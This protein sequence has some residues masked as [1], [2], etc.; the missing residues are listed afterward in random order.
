MSGDSGERWWE[1]PPSKGS[2]PPPI[3][4]PMQ[5]P[6]QEGQP[7]A[8]GYPAPPSYPPSY[9]QPQ[10]YPPPPYPQTNQGGY[11]PHYQPGYPS[12]PRSHT[13]GMAIGSLVASGLA[14]PLGFLRVGPLAAIVGVV[15]GI[16]ALNQIKQSGENGRGLA[17]AG[18]IVGGLILA[19]TVILF[20]VG[21]AWFAMNPYR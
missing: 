15:L 7:P 16:I 8:P 13:N 5:P 18:I 11:P 12:P 9:Q 4:P 1:Q 19:L 6:M 10:S 3:Q 17:L 20:I 21:F 2:E 14:I